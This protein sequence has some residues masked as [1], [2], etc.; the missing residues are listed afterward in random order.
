MDTLGTIILD[1]KRKF[2]T[3]FYNNEEITLRDCTNKLDSEDPPLEE[4][5][6]ALE[7]VQDSQKKIEKL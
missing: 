6:D 3:F 2:L 4:K 1:T 7:F 5:M